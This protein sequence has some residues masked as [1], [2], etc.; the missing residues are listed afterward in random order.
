MPEPVII[1]EELGHIARNLVPLSIVWH[2]A[3]GVAVILLLAGWRPS[4]PA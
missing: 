4:R 1:L 3:F 2:I